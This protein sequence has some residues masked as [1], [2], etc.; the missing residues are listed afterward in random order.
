MSLLKVYWHFFW[1]K[2]SFGKL[3]K[4]NNLFIAKSSEKRKFVNF[5]IKDEED[6]LL[7]KK[8]LEEF[9]KVIQKYKYKVFKQEQIINGILYKLGIVDTNYLQ[10]P[11][12]E[13]LS[14]SKLLL[15]KETIK[16]KTQNQNETNFYK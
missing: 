16:Y 2:Y 6:K 11:Y 13:K 5:F 7:N 3:K 10:L 14:D 8:V 12:I 4:Y 15:I 9:D 1:L